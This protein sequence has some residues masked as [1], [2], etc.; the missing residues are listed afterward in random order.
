[1]KINIGCGE[2]R[3]III[4]NKENVFAW[5]IFHSLHFSSVFIPTLS[6][7]FPP[8]FGSHFASIP[9]VENVDCKPQDYCM[10]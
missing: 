10:S 6:I 4:A 8:Q 7:Y 3:K 5:L 9:L 2:L 1:M